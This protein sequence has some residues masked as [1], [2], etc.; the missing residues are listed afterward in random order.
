[1]PVPYIR[2]VIYWLDELTDV[3]LTCKRLRDVS[4]LYFEREYQLLKLTILKPQ[5]RDHIKLVPNEVHFQMEHG[6]IIKEILKN[7]KTLRV[8]GAPASDLHDIF[9][10]HCFH[11]VNLKIISMDGVKDTFS[12]FDQSLPAMR[13]LLMKISL[14]ASEQMRTDFQKCI[15]KNG[16]ATCFCFK[17]KGFLELFRQLPENC[18][19]VNEL[20]VR[21]DVK[22]P[23]LST[24]HTISTPSTQSFKTY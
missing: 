9:L 20:A 14:S 5:L 21:M 13:Q 15:D 2:L 8:F 18:I 3:S 17:A 10:R 24:C 19:K 6:E 23:I 1:M 7:V 12:L 11:L 16:L 22:R 4:A